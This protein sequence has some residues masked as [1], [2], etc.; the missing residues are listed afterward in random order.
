VDGTR[1]QP[2]PAPVDFGSSADFELVYERGPFIWRL[3]GS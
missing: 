1:P 2:C 3:I